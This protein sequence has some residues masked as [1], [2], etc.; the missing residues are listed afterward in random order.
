MQQYKNLLSDILVNGEDDTDR[1]G[2]GTR[3]VFGRSM[4]FDLS[5]GFPADSLRKVAFRIAFEETMFFL[6]GESDTTK[7]E[8]KKINIWKGNTSREFLDKVGLHHLPVGDMGRG[9]GV[10]WRNFRTATVIHSGIQIEHNGSSV[11]H[12]N[13][14]VRTKSVDQL[15]EL[16]DGLKNNP[17]GRRHMIT[18]W[19]PAELD[20]MALPPCHYAHQYSIKGGKLHSSWNQRS[21]DSVYGLPYNIMS[22]A[23]LNEAIARLVKV[24]PGTVTFFGGDVHIYEN[25]R[26]MAEDMVATRDPLPLPTLVIHKELNT[27]GDLLSLEFS[28]VELQNYTAH[29]DYKNKPPMAV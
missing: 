17:T 23:F 3:S 26:W 24:K 16:I 12:L 27:L 4:T 20:Q 22:Y 2:V 10:Q 8:A 13:A 25:Q 15:K 6:R 18:A 11:T 14:K 19:N 28:D 5:E 7:L 9:Y 1:T 29:P 21:V